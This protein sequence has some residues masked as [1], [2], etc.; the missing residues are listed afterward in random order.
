MLTLL[1]SLAAVTATAQTAPL[2]PAP[3]LRVRHSDLD[4]SRPRDR[5]IFD[6]RIAR[7]VEALCPTHQLGQITRSSAGLQC[8]AET[9][10][11]LT[12]QRDRAVA[13]ATAPVL[14]TAN[15]R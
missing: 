10:A 5:E 4:L 6:R 7:A 3:T 13:Q 1:L 8:R 2:E 12:P 15:A 9:L 14:L 11:R